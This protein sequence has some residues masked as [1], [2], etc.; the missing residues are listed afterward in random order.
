MKSNPAKTPVHKPVRLK[1]RRRRRQLALFGASILGAVLIAGGLSALSHLD[2]FEINDVVVEGTNVISNDALASHVEEGANDAQFHIF[3]RENIFLYPKSA[4]I[5][6]VY[7]SFPRV[8]EVSIKRVSLFAQAIAVT[9]A[10]REQY[11]TWCTGAKSPEA[12]STPQTE[13]Y[14]MDSGGFI[15]DTASSIEPIGYVYYGGLFPNE[16]PIGQTFLRGR[17]SE[18]VTL[19]N[20]LSG[21]GFTARSLSI[22]SEKNFT[23]SLSDGPDLYLS[24]DVKP[25]ESVRNLVTALEAESLHSRLSELEYI[26]LRYGN[27]VYYK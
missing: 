21:A 4:L 10:E 20:D 22:E 2:R 6:D 14:A 17:L 3:S 25:K 12:S 24:F 7:T 11:A 18:I 16:S 23:V 1:T 13:C 27:R 19:L 8:K 9:I 15:F 26:N 5:E